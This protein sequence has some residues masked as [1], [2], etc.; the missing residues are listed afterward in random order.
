[1]N[2]LITK[3]RCG[4]ARRERWGCAPFEAAPRIREWCQRAF[5][6]ALG[7]GEDG[8][9][10][11]MK[12]SRRPTDACNR[13]LDSFDRVEAETMN[14]MEGCQKGQKTL[15]TIPGS[16]KVARRRCTSARRWKFAKAKTEPQP[17]YSLRLPLADATLRG[18]LHLR[19]A[20]LHL[21]RRGCNVAPRSFA[22]VSNFALAIVDA[23]IAS[24]FWHLRAAV[25]LLLGSCVSAPRRRK[26][27]P[28][29]CKVE[30]SC[31]SVRIMDNL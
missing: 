8:R 2:P 16:C 15:S 19:L 23:K 28:R 22:S 7:A 21:P 1:L 9:R 3:G 25:H 30:C 10:A 5:D 24:Q 12:T 26:V 20:T 31:G 17:H 29:R 18:N 11:A 27:A 4:A 13:L 6:A 14:A